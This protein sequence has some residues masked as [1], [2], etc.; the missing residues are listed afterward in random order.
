MLD[1]KGET[2]NKDFTSPVE[3]DKHNGGLGLLLNTRTR[4]TLEGCNAISSRLIM[5]RFNVV[6]LKINQSQRD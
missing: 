6:L 5:A 3:N 4:Q 2:S 1:R